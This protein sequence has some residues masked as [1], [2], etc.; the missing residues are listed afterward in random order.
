VKVVLD[1]NIY[2]SAFGFDRGPEQIIDLGR[3]TNFKI[4]TS[5]YIVQ[6]VK[7][8]LVEK[9]GFSERFATLAE[10]RI[11][12]FSSVVAIRGSSLKGPSPVD[13]KDGPIIKTCLA[14]RADFLVTGDSRLLE[15][16]VRGLE[17]VSP[18]QFLRRLKS[19]GVL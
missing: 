16:E 17:V 18:S 4:Y 13:P 12:R 5:L 8:V 9:L 19:Q 7:R 2:V 10:K 6:E 3:A 11:I 1:S 14:S 15:L